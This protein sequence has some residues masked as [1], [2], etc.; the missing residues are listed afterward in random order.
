MCSLPKSSFHPSPTWSL[1]YV[2]LCCFLCRLGS[3]YFAQPPQSTTLSFSPGDPTSH[4]CP[5]KVPHYHFLLG[6]LLAILSP[7]SCQ[8]VWRILNQSL[9]LI[10]PSFSVPL[11]WL[12]NLPTLQNAFKEP[13]ME[14]II[15]FPQLYPSPINNQTTTTGVKQE[16]WSP[17]HLEGPKGWESGGYKIGLENLL[18]YLIW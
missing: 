10:E 11:H 9:S 16:A 6:V 4:P 18:L 15:R 1:K 13:R 7:T 2:W 3:G 8:G 14:A 17:L 12:T 5:R